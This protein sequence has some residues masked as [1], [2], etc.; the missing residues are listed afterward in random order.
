[1]AFESYQHHEVQTASNKIMKLIRYRYVLHG[2]Y[3][4]QRVK[5]VDTPPLKIPPSFKLRS[6]CG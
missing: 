6:V 4:I 2:I 3:L 5:K 1:M